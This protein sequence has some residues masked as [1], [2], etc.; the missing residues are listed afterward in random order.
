[1]F[2]RELV[3]D[4]TQQEVVAPAP[5]PVKLQLVDEDYDSAPTKC[6]VEP[7]S[8]LVPQDEPTTAIAT[9]RQF[10]SDATAMLSDLTEARPLIR[11]ELAMKT[12]DG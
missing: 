7:P 8:L 2:T 5:W 6:F 10:S 9:M 11:T 12:Y 4:P 1:L 3:I